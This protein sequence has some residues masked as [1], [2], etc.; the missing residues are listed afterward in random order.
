[1]NVHYAYLYDD[2]LN[3]HK[4]ERDIAAVESKLNTFDLAGRVSRLVLFRDPKNLLESLAKQRINTVV[5]VGNDETLYK[6]V[7]F[8]PDLNLTVG[9][10]PI[11]RPW[12]VAE[13]LN[14]PIGARA[15]DVLAARYVEAFDMGKIGDQYFFSEL[16]IP[17]TRAGLEVEGRY[18]VSPAHDGSLSIRNLCSAREGSVSGLADAN[19]GLLE[20]VIAPAEEKK[21]RSLWRQPRAAEADTRLLLSYGTI[22]SDE[23]IEV[24]ADGRPMRG[25]KFEV[26]VAADKLNF[27]T[28]RGRQLA[29]VDDKLP[30]K[31][32]N[33]NIRQRRRWMRG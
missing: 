33:V 4:Y 10:I 1:M 29:P 16:Y 7:G 28:G 9:Y 15:C 22:V 20:A 14:I 12:R 3:D 8:M 17:H 32:K 13:M 26:D 21:S 23:V 30:K 2:F 19:D 25:K 11:E 31:E 27:I 24:L 5:V 18:Q 6:T